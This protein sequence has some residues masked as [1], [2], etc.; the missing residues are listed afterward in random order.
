VVD[1]HEFWTNGLMAVT[2]SDRASP[3][4]NSPSRRYHARAAAMQASSMASPRPHSTGR[5]RP[6]PARVC[7]CVC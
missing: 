4:T 2:T 5:V 1:T 6:P 3:R 7:L